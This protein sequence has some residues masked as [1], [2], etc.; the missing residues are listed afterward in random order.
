MRLKFWGVRGSIAAPLSNEAIE[1]KTKALLR[2][3]LKRNVKSDK[4]IQTFWKS[5]P[6]SLKGTYGGNTSCIT[7]H[8]D[9]DLIVLDAGTGLRIFGKEIA[10]TGRQ[11][12][13]P[14]HIFLSHF[15]WDHIGGF[16]F[17]APAFQKGTRIVIHSPLEEGVKYFQVQQSSPFSPAEFAFLQASIDFELSRDI[18]NKRVSAFR[19]SSLAMEHPGGSTAYRVEGDSG[20]LVYMTDTELANVGVEKIKEYGEFF[21]GATV[22]VVDAM[23]GLLETYTSKLRWG[24]SS[25]FP[26]IDIVRNTTVKTLALFHHDPDLDDS[27]IEEMLVR[28]QKYYEHNTPGGKLKILCAYDGLTLDV[29]PLD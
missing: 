2:L 4:Q 8:Q 11:L 27:D 1:A 6:L 20:G 26:F 24:H 17:F 9:D 3:A 15:H 19:V 21:N 29:P 25:V 28:A 16:P 5:L 12:D 18:R 14:L 22:A 23:Y 7:V 13:K 10:S